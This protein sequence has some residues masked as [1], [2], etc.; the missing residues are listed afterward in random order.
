[1]LRSVLLTSASV[2]ILILFAPAGSYIGPDFAFGI[3]PGGGAGGAG[4]VGGGAGGLGGGAGGVGGGTGGLGGGA[5]GVGGGAG[6]LG[7][8]GVGGVGGGAGGIGGG[9][10]GAAGGAAG[11]AGG[12]AAGAAGGLGGAAGGGAGGLAGGA[13]AGGAAANGPA[14]AG[15]SGGPDGRD[16][17]SLSAFIASPLFTRVGPAVSSTVQASSVY[18]ARGG[19][20]C[21]TV[22]QTIDIGGQTVHA[23][24]V[25]CRE[26]SGIWR[27][28]PMQDAA[29]YR[30]GSGTAVQ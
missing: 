22:T 2:F 25:L 6:G 28:D 3:G 27:I 23:S 11:A 1:M 21:Q 26:P 24:A 10:A 15:G 18:T 30:Q 12:A 29:G 17:T 16:S 14:N 19:L 4:G 7:G 9:A 5:G 20:P 13:S 8:G